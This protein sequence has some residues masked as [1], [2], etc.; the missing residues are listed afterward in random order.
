M[1]DENIVLIE[2]FAKR[3]FIKN[4]EKK[5]KNKWDIT[6][7]ALKEMLSRIDQLIQTQNAETIIAGKDIDIIKI[8]FKIAG[9][10]ES[11]KSSGNR[12]IVSRD[13]NKK[14][15]KILLVYAKTD[16]QTKNETSIWKMIIRNNYKEY[17]SIITI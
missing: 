10:N 9:T 8:Y 13:K 4:F 15:I 17:K 3:H 2:D 16:I 7:E 1:M 6:I 14:L 12:C 5:Y 11:A